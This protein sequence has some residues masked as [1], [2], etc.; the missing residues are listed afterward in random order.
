MRR[1]LKLSL[2]VAVVL[3]LAVWWWMPSKVERIPLGNIDPSFQGWCVTDL[4]S[5]GDAEILI[6]YPRRTT[7]LMGL[8][9]D[10]LEFMDLHGFDSVVLP[11]SENPHSLL[12]PP[13]K[14]VP[15]KINGQFKL[16]RLKGG[17]V[18]LEPFPKV[19]QIDHVV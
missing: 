7:I 11:S 5:D 14:A 12:L 10:N 3:G 2:I 16:A 8:Q 6:T 4:D 9:K 1:L 13:A 18:V 17:Q 15:A 19:K